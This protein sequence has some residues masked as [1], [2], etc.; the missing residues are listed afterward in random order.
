MSN[1]EEN[2]QYDSNCNIRAITKNN[3]LRNFINDDSGRLNSEID[4]ASVQYDK[5]GNV[6]RVDSVIDGLQIEYSKDDDG[7]FTDRIKYLTSSKLGKLEFKYDSIGNPIKYM[8]SSSI[9]GNNMTW[10]RGHILKSYNGVNFEYSASGY[11]TKKNDKYF[12][13][14]GDKIIAESIKENELEDGK[15]YIDVQYGF[16]GPE[17]LNV[18][19]QTFG[20]MYTYNLLKDLRGNVKAI[21]RTDGFT[22]TLMAEYE[23]DS[24][25]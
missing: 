10:A 1:Y 11:R 20:L 15:G 6:V 2:Y 3:N 12:F 25:S 17:A 8:Q 14:D 5:F 4:I 22:T 9:Q 18:S 16:S 19:P 24:W 13:L 23:Y 7:I 21:T